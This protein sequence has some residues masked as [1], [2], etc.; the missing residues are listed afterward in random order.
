MTAPIPV[1]TDMPVLSFNGVYFQHC[2]A[3]CGFF[4]VLDYGDPKRDHLCSRDGQLVRVEW[5]AAA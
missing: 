2:C 1:L 4:Q 5:S 3:S